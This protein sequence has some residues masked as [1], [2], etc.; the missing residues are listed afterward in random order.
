MILIP[1]YKNRYKGID[2]IRGN[3]GRVPPR[4]DPSCCITYATFSIENGKCTDISDQLYIDYDGKTKK[5]DQKWYDHFTK[6]SK[7]INS[8][9]KS[10]IKKLALDH[11]L[12]ESESGNIVED[13]CTNMALEDAPDFIMGRSFEYNVEEIWNDYIGVS[14][15][16][17]QKKMSI[18]E[19]LQMMIISDLVDV[20]H[21]DWNEAE[22]IV[23][24]SSINK[25][26]IEDYHLVID[27]DP[28]EVTKEIWD[29]YMG[30]P[31]EI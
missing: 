27:R 4:N 21:V 12:T 31:I 29:E 22:Q 9:R 17:V 15:D 18:K 3:Q 16:T 2:D 13:S 26:I 28:D 19:Q 8:Y 25:Q 1:G 20:Y 30:I 6:E 24:S 10:L 23:L 7:R 14:E 5:K 11:N